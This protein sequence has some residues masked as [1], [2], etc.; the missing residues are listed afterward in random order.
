MMTVGTSLQNNKFVLEETLDQSDFGVTYRAHHTYMNRPVLLQTLNPVLRQRSDFDSLRQQ[1]FETLRIEVQKSP[2]SLPVLDCFEE[3]GLPFA[4]LEPPG[5]GSIPRL[6]DWLSI[7]LLD[8]D[9]PTSEASHSDATPFLPDVTPPEIVEMAAVAPPE[10]LHEATGIAHAVD[11][12]HRDSATDSNH[13]AAA[14][15]S[16]FQ[17]ESQEASATVSSDAFVES[18]EAIAVINAVP[19]EA[20]IAP[21]SDESA[22]IA[23]APVAPSRTALKPFPFP[24]QGKQGVSILVGEPGQKKRRSLPLILLLTMLIGSFGG[25]GLGLAL[26]LNSQPSS[27]KGGSMSPGWFGREQTFPSQ[28]D[29]PVTEPPTLYPTSPSLEQP[30]F[31]NS[32][33]PVEYRT[34][35]PTPSF[36]VYTPYS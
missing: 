18:G 31:R 26:R 34:P 12:Q 7:P 28:Q 3:D 33:S 25:V 17:T 15:N 4:V 2:R 30:L 11:L 36:Q 27:E 35:K 16:E 22:T 6:K 32:P 24:G 21:Q 29:W 1:F 23:V 20:A 9:S 19:P 13:H 8:A 5:D 14:A 10:S